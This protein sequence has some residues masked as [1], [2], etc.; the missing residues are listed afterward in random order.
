MGEPE[1]VKVWFDS[2]GRERLTLLYK[3]EEVVTIELPEE[4]SG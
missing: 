1:V 4:A 2:M 3:V